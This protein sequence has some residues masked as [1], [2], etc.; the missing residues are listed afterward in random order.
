MVL[1]N[2]HLPSHQKRVVAFFY[3]RISLTKPGECMFGKQI[4]TINIKLRKES[5]IKEIRAEEVI[6][7]VSKEIK[8][9]AIRETNN[10]EPFSGPNAGKAYFRCDAC[11]KLYVRNGSSIERHS[12]SKGHML[13]VGSWFLSQK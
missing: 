5:V 9:S 6:A 2:F 12:K 1:V 13:K 11:N 7:N 3:N 10:G 8:S 4:D